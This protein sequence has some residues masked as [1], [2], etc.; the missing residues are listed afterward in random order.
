M[1]V[2]SHYSLT[3]LTQS[4]QKRLV[5][6]LSFQNSVLQVCTTMPGFIFFETVSIVQD[7]FKLAAV[8]LF[9]KNWDQEYIAGDNL[10]V[11]F[12]VEWICKTGME[13]SLS[14]PLSGVS[15]FIYRNG[16]CLNLFGDRIILCS[17]GWPRTSFVDQAGLK[18]VEIQS[19][20]G[21]QMQRLKA[22]AIIPGY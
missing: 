1:E 19:Y 16:Y 21:S 13:E 11:L 22:S 2:T 17:S 6:D 9:Q 7:G 8:L 4:I 3:K 14:I 15:R 12:Q 10:F 5:S 20:S 18:L